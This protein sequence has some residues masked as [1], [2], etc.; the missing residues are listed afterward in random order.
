MSDTFQPRDPFTID[1]PRQYN[2]GPSDEHLHAM[3]QFIANYSAVEWQLSELFA[4]FLKKSV[5]EAQKL[6]VEAN[7][8]I[9]GMIRYVEGQVYEAGAIDK[10]ASD[11]LI[12]TL[13]SFESITKLRNKIVHWQWG[14]NEGPTASLTDLIKPRNPKS[15]NATLKIQD[16]RNQCLTLMRVLQAIALNG[17]I[18][19]GQMTRKQILETRKGTS[20]EK[21]FR[22]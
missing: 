17:A 14:L 1:W 20:P 13:K 15:S 4:F 19:K 11:D 9:A 6:A 8:S 21:L 7:I 2:V 5:D 10:Q 22:P 3:G 12:Q 18:I 16:L